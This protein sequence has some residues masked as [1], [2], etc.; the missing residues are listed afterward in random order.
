[1]VAEDG[2]LQQ[3][4]KC[5]EWW[6]ADADHYGICDKRPTGLRL[7]CLACR[8]ERK[9]ERPNSRYRLILDALRKNDMNGL[10]TAELIDCLGIEHTNAN[11]SRVGWC[12]SRAVR[13]GDAVRTH[14]KRRHPE[15]AKAMCVYLPAE[16]S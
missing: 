1:M 7:W 14:L 11:T 8:Q 13:S 5:N 2:L 15:H 10:T 16:E 9:S 4:S 6:P 12:V 3:C